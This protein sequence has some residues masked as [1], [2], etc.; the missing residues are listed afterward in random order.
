MMRI[1]LAKTSIFKRK[2]SVLV[3]IAFMVTVLG[4]LFFSIPKFGDGKLLLDTKTAK[5]YTSP[6]N[7]QTVELKVGESKTVSGLTVKNNGGGNMRD[8]S[9]MHPSFASISI[10]SSNT[11]NIDTRVVSE[12]DLGTEKAV[13]LF[14]GYSIRVTNIGFNG[15][16]V[17]LEVTPE[18]QKERELVVPLEVDKNSHEV[19]VAKG[20]TVTVGD[21]MITVSSGGQKRL[22]SPD[23]GDG[24]DV[25]FA[26][27]RLKTPRKEELEKL[28]MGPRGNEPV[29]FE[30][31]NYSVETKSIEQ[32]GETATLVVREVRSTP[33]ISEK[34]EAQMVTLNDGETA[35]VDDLSLTIRGRGHKILMAGGSGRS[36]DM[37]MV[38]LTLETPR[39]EKKT[40]K[41]KDS[42]ENDS[43]PIV[44]D[45]YLIFIKQIAWNGNRVTVAVKKLP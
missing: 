41:I 35:L 21:I 42:E 40:M 2:Y 6:M 29:E 34:V 10:Q 17:A 22:R 26:M 4:T 3:G 30:Y 23:G 33:Q 7:T 44:F 32:N 19:V 8:R 38:D 36:G 24:D 31:D 1:S 13:S 12:E 18:E 5:D 25:Y 15:E 16:S 11:K 9:G 45:N 27:L 37:S 20:E 14:E 43:V 39:K 28:V